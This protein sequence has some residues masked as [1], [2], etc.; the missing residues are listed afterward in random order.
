MGLCVPTVGGPRR[1]L[2][3]RR[4]GGS[5]ESISQA[6]VSV[7]CEGGVLCG[8]GGECGLEVGELGLE[9][10]HGRLLLPLQ[11]RQGLHMRPTHHK[12][13]GQKGVRRRDRRVEGARV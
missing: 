3:K 4:E 11:Q 6:Y 13:R 1:R 2:V 10:R 5:S 9:G 12:S 8:E 7:L